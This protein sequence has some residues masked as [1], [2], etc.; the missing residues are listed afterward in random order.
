MIDRWKEA[1]EASLK[2]EDLG[3]DHASARVEIAN[4]YM[5]QKQWDKA[6]PYAEQAAMTWAEWAMVCAGRCAEG[7]KD[8]NRA[9]QWYSRATQRYPSTDWA[10][11]YFFCKRTGQGNL[12][13]ALIC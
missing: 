10:A 5:E 11:W 9:E 4:Y 7:E 13:A 3:L 12:E 2:E 1:L 6:R 8:W